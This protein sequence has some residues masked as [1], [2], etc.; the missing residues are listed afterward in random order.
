MRSLFVCPLSRLPETLKFSGARSLVSLLGAG[1]VF[2]RPASIEAERHLLLGL[3]DISVAR[4][5]H[6]LPQ[7]EQ[8]RQ[9][10]DFVARS[11]GAIAMHC[12][13]GVSRST[14]AAFVL[15]CA[16]APH[17]PEAEIAAQLRALSPTATPNSLIVALGDEILSR[18]GRM[19]AAISTIG[20]GAECFEGVPFR[21]DLE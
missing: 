21:L 18:G 11:E 6:V 2:D 16:H 7:A 8:V 1:A 13:A 12:Y 15:A 9:L 19:S 20:R 3:S 4:D 17:R 10:I 14:A 5:G